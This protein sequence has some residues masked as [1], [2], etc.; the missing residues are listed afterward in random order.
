MVLIDLLLGIVGKHACQK[1]L[2]YLD[3]KYDGVRIQ[4]LVTIGA[5]YMVVSD[6][7]GILVTDNF[8]TT[9]HPR[10]SQISVLDASSLGKAPDD[11]W[12]DEG[13]IEPAMCT[14]E[15]ATID[16]VWAKVEKIPEECINIY[17]LGALGRILGKVV[18]NFT[19]LQSGYEK[20][21]DAYTRYIKE[22]VPSKLVEFMA[23]KDGPGNKYFTCTINLGDSQH[24]A[25]TGKCPLSQ[26]NLR[27]YDFYTIYYHLDDD[28]GFFKELL[29]KKGIDKPWVKFGDKTEAFSCSRNRTGYCSPFR[30]TQRGFPLG[31]DSYTIPDPKE[32]V[33]AA[34]PGWRI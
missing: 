24:N 33:K 17:K 11:L 19:D 8:A 25:S 30:H 26:Y 2:V 1:A 13:D 21:F 10:W 16:D 22:L 23:W 18:N 29:E 4:H 27:D 7:K 28:N 15:Y 34:I 14:D 31:A 9:A 6:G 20:K 32:M 3:G 5:K 12:Q